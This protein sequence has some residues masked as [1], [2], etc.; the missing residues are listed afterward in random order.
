MG[1]AGVLVAATV[2]DVFLSLAYAES[3]AA[4][5]PE[6]VWIMIGGAMHF[7]LALSMYALTAARLLKTQALLYV[8]SAT[9]T[10]VA[11]LAWVPCSGLMGAAQASAL[12]LSVGATGAMLAVAL[13][14]FRIRSGVH[15]V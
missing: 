14:W 1:G 5:Q 3:F 15:H 6:F 2:G 11:A 12:G 4:Y 10:G 7:V 8:V 13:A 9:T